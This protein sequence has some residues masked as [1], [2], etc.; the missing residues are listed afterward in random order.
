MQ[1]KQR[2]PPVPSLHFVATASPEIH[3]NTLHHTLQHAATASPAIDIYSM[4]CRGG[5]NNITT[6]VTHATTHCATYSATHLATHSATHSA[7]LVATH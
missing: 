1:P 4:G 5:S 6:T 7:T 3:R 2:F